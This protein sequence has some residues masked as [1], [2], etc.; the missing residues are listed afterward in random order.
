MT[1]V[2]LRLHHRRLSF[3]PLNGLR[4]AEGSRFQVDVVP[5]QPARLTDPQAEEATRQER[6][7]IQRL[8]TI[9]GLNR[10]KGDEFEKLVVTLFERDGYSVRRCG[11]AGDGGLD[12]VVSIG[13]V[14]DVVQCKRWKSE[15][16]PAVVREFY[17]AMIHAAARHGFIVTTSTFSAASRD[18]ALNKPITL[19]DGAALLVWLGDGT[20]SARRAASDD[21]A[22]DPWLELGVRRGA[23][24]AEVRAAYKD[25]I[26]KYHPDRVAQL[27]PEIQ[28]FAKKK[29]QS[30]NRAYDLL[31][32]QNGWG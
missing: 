20:F 21:R 6:E 8:Q 30:I 24:Q 9:D 5:A 2:T 19:I 1:G 11:G 16:G 13:D 18:F 15:V 7:R 10:L 4:D 32:K 31:R 26:A 3:P 12:I 28:D 29:A 25:T 22:F 23:S 17:G 27:A 14:I